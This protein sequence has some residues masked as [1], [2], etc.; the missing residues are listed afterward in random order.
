MPVLLVVVEGYLAEQWLHHSIHFRSSQ[1]GYFRAMKRYHLYHH[2]PLG[3]ERGFGLSSWFWD[4]VF[5]TQFPPPVEDALFRR[6]SASQ[7]GR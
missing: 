4:I 3:M 2:S 6:R 1:N 5:K 7:A